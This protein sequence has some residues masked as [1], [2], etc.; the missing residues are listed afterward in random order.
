MNGLDFLGF[1]FSC[2]I[3][4]Q[5]AIAVCLSLG[6][7]VFTTVG[8]PDK[9]AYLKSVF[10]QLTDRNFANSRDLSFEYHILKET[11]GEG[12]NTDLKA[13]LFECLKQAF[14]CGICNMH[15][16]IVYGQQICY[17]D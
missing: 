15:I 4:R 13:T 7:E 17:R 5:A 11:N 12:E 3:S 8:T 1:T 6:C 16:S 10:P 9:V 2:L 14:G